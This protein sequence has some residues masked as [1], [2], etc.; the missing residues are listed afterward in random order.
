[1]RVAVAARILV[2]AALL[3]AASS[4]TWSAD[5]SGYLVLT[6]D[7]VWR[8]VTQSE[9]DPAAQ[10]GGDVAF[11]SG[12]YA[13]IW[14]STIDIN[15]GGDRQRDTELT[16]YLGYSHD[17]GT[18]WSLGASVI[19]YTYPGQ[20]GAVDYNYEEVMLTVNFDDRAWLEYAY[21]PDLY[22]TG[23]DSHNI[24]LFA[25]FPAG[26][27]LVVGGGVGYYDVSNFAGD[28]YAYW[29]LGVTLPVHRFDFDL[30]YHDTS[31][32][33]PVISTPE[34]ADSRIAF[35]VRLTF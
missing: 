9:G 10:L 15:N 13:G 23:L 26:K 21:S 19:V 11:N 6:T 35:S 32:W 18:R 16:Y 3:S 2:S 30:R 29:E 4:T 24:E 7:Y 22:N 1:M 17:I 33:V 28:G 25:E 27:R 5:L 20:T 34:R 31:R 8:G 12:I 14:G